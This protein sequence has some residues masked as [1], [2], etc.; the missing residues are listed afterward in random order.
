[1]QYV[2]VHV[3]VHVACTCTCTYKNGYVHCKIGLVIATGNNDYYYNIAAAGFSKHLVKVAP[4]VNPLYVML[5]SNT[6]VGMIAIY[7]IGTI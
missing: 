3:H 1:M 7:S 2:H 5:G 4:K 6:C